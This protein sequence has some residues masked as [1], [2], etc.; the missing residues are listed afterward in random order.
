LVALLA[1]NALDVSTARADD[2]SYLMFEVVDT[3]VL[4]LT[5]PVGLIVGEAD[6]YI[7][8]YLIGPDSTVIGS[9]KTKTVKSQ[10]IG[11]DPHTGAK[12]K[13]C[14]DG[15]PAEV[16]IQV[17]DEDWKKDDLLTGVRV[18]IGTPPQSFISVSDKFELSILYY[19]RHQ[20]D[21]PLVDCSGIPYLDRILPPFLA[22]F[23]DTIGV[24]LNLNV[25]SAA[26]VPVMVREYIPTGFRYVTDSADPVLTSQQSLTD[27]ASLNLTV[28]EWEFNQTGSHAISYDVITP[29][30]WVQLAKP[31]GSELEWADSVITGFST[32]NSLAI[33]IET[34]CNG[35]DVLDIVDIVHG[36]SEDLNENT[37]PDECEGRGTRKL[38]P[39]MEP[40]HPSRTSPSTIAHLEQNYPNPANPSTTI[41]YT[42]AER[43]RVSLRIYSA[44][45]RLVKTLVDEIQSPRNVTTVE[46]NGRNDAGQ[47]VST[48]VYFYR[49]VTKD[50]VDTKKLVLLK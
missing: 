10:G 16:W 27:D 4:K 2:K 25:P 19:E 14:Y 22:E 45:G 43:A 44:T 30:S 32:F 47:P 20:T 31:F 18:P 48:G 39:R 41:P 50:F 33:G 28:L 49:L 29:N 1:T 46:W 5:D 35:N 9:A 8:I 24:F 11:S 42:I 26:T 17:W 34:D 3:K 36:T 40:E 21:P 23:L 12:I 13:V 38:W 7:S 37:V 6:P 15:D